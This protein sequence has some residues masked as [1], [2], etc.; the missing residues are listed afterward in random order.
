MTSSIRQLGSLG[1]PS[2]GQPGSVGSP[3][4]GGPGSVGELSAGRPGSLGALS[5]GQPGSAGTPAGTLDAEWRAARERLQE[6]ALRPGPTVVSC[7]APFGKGGLG[8]HLQEILDALGRRGEQASCLCNP[9]APPGTA[10]ARTGL[11]TRAGLWAA[12]P[13]ARLSPA[14]RAWRTSVA[15]DATAARRLVSAEHLIAFNG[16]ALGQF[17]AARRAGMESLALMSATVHLR[18][19]VRQHAS[20]HAR[21]PFERSWASRLLRRNLREYA[22]ADHIY[23]SSRYAWESFLAEGVAEER[24][25]LFP[26]TPSPRFSPDP[27]PARRASPRFDVVYVGGMS[28]AKGVPLLVD[29]FNRLAH[30]DMRLLLV[31]GAETRGMRRFL[32]RACARDPRI[33]VL[34]GDPL[35]VLR[36]ARLYVHP[37]YTDGFGYAPAEALACGLP[38]LVSEDT[39]MKELIDSA[40]D[41]LVLPTG[42]LDALTEAIDCAYRGELRGG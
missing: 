1:S 3:A 22:R 37:S 20:A 29:A 27:A 5:A 11:V 41:G 19:V 36:A 33:E 42:D 18:S 30:G 15:F 2:A 16:Q 12:A 14:W 21:H 31:G 8:R 28:V 25:S 10:A 40:R 34:P 24:L 13:P 38:V 7:A 32:E 6:A 17:G 26:L 9:L 35:P 23:V 4:A 39:G